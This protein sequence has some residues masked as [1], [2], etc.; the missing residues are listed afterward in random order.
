MALAEDPTPYRAGDPIRFGHILLGGKFPAWFG[1]DRGPFDL[2]GC[3]AT[4]DQCQI[5]TIAG[6]LT[7][8]GPSVRVTADMATD[9][10][11]TPCPAGRAT[12]GSPPGTRAASTTISRDGRRSSGARARIVPAVALRR[13][14]E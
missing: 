8:G 4:V 13:D 7:A 11:V 3:R 5:V 1:F 12:G 9:E 2:H 6:R 10:L 14:K